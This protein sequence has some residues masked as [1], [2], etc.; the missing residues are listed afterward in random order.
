MP[1]ALFSCL[2]L[3]VALPACD[4]RRTPRDAFVAGDDATPS[5]DAPDLDAPERPDSGRRDTDL[6]PDARLDAAVIMDPDAGMDA[7]VSIDAAR[8]PDAFTRDAPAASDTRIDTGV[9]SRTLACAPVVPSGASAGLVFS[10]MFW[11]GFRF[12]I[13]SPTRATRVGLQLTPDRAGTFFAGLVRLT[14]SSDAPDAADLSG[15]DVIARVDV[16]VPASATPIVVGADVD[17]ALSP[18]WYALVFGTDAV[19]GSLPSGGGTGCVSSP[20]SS[21]P[22]SIRQSDGSL[23]LQG[24]EPHLFVDVAP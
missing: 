12:E 20:G 7:L 14:G 4:E 8:A 24:A 13:T 22:F 18:G 10:A 1:R 6:N 21:Y 17:V 3:L 5:I 23:I 9:T 11:P 2:L 15:A 19:G 16:T